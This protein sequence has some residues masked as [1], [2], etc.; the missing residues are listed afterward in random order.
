MAN[1]L[2]NYLQEARHE[3]KK[4]AWPTRKEV[5]QNTIVVVVISLVT[6]AFLGVLDYFFNLGLS[7]II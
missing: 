4:V 6:A 1:K 2:L 7:K 3:L 5:V